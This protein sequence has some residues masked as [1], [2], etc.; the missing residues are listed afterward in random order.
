M[1]N[2]LMLALGLMMSSS[3]FAAQDKG[4]VVGQGN[5][6][7]DA[8]IKAAGAKNVAST[9]VRGASLATGFVKGAKMPKNSRI[10]LVEHKVG[11]KLKV[12]PVK[13][14][15]DRNVAPSKMSKA[16]I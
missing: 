9:F 16:Q 8:V 10:M 15:L 7:R 1:R 12:T 3:A 6:R 5:F 14:P 2:A 13:A 11:G 4:K